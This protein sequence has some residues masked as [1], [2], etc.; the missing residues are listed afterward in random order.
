VNVISEFREECGFQLNG[1]SSCI[2][3]FNLATAASQIRMLVFFFST[4]L[5]SFAGFFNRIRNPHRRSSRFSVAD[6]SRKPIRVAYRLSGDDSLTD[7]AK[8]ALTTTFDSLTKFLADLVSVDRYSGQITV[9]NNDPDTIKEW[10][11]YTADDSDLLLVIQ[12][13]SDLGGVASTQYPDKDAGC[14]SATAGRRLSAIVTINPGEIPTAAQTFEDRHNRRFFMALLHEAI[15]ALGFQP[16]AIPCWS[17]PLAASD[18]LVGP[19]AHYP[20]I[21]GQG[22]YDY[23]LK[24]AHASQLAKDQFNVDTGFPLQLVATGTEGIDPME[25]HSRPVLFPEDVTQPTSGAWRVLSN[26]TIA[27]LKDMGWYDVNEKLAEPVYF[28][29]DGKQNSEVVTDYPIKHLPPNYLCTPKEV[30]CY[31]NPRMIGN[32]THVFVDNCGRDDTVSCWYFPLD[33]DEKGITMSKDY[34]G[35]PIVLPGASCEQPSPVVDSE[36]LP[37]FGRQSFC[38]VS[39]LNHVG[40]EAAACYE[41]SCVG[42]VVTVK[43]AGHGSQACAK[44]GDKIEFSGVPGQI[45][46]P[47]TGLVCEQATEDA[48]MADWLIAV[49]VSVSVVGGGVVI[50]VTVV[51]ARPHETAASGEDDARHEED[52]EQ[53]ADATQV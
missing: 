16:E 28:L 34:E 2:E 35:V 47:D 41:M 29:N 26:A 11:T 46:C 14:P 18:R 53:V 15:H 38:A 20:L 30:R 51:V 27:L 21:G 39:T 45:T 43:V 6:S 12:F 8:T 32:C 4:G 33:M 5:C 25:P 31:V 9:T 13:K 3:T 19:V 17:N 44:A 24:T 1:I 10:V 40:E 42:G 23:T 52:A 48:T 22:I 49:I 37:T 36:Y 50:T 7:G